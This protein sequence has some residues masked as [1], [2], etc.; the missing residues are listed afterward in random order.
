MPSAGPDHT[1]PS[2][3]DIAAQAYLLWEQAGRPQGRAVTH[4]LEAE[5]ALTPN[6][7]RTSSSR[8]AESPRG[9]YGL[10]LQETSM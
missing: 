3:D 5:A 9:R 4:W 7:T 1:S 8:K 2:H 6:Q 10:V